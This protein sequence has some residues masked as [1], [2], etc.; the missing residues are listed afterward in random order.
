MSASAYSLAS[1]AVASVGLHAFAV[2]AL[3][4]IPPQDRSPDG[5][6]VEVSLSLP[7]PPEVPSVQRE[8]EAQPEAQPEREPETAP[9]RR[10]KARAE[11][12]QTPVA[13]PLAMPNPQP[14]GTG[15]L[16]LT[17]TTLTAPGGGWA[18][19]PGTGAPR[20]GPIR[21]PSGPRPRPSWTTAPPTTPRTIVPATSLAQPPRP[22]NLDATLRANYPPSA[23]A[24]GVAG[25]AV[26]TVQVAADGLAGGV[27]VV[28]ESFAGFGEACRRTV[29]GSVWKPLRD[30]AG[31]PHA[32][33]VRYRCR[34]R[35]D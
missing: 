6:H 5:V 1:G 33:A 35:V 29:M 10:P 19:D 17:G 15:P 28:G 20:Q 24:R 23:R 32:T 4:A 14:V 9:Q 25:E 34:F 21:T 22:P 18:A 30:A 3:S 26:V 7:S 2:A 13:Q 31:R 27:V 11:P 16:D 12:A 8:P